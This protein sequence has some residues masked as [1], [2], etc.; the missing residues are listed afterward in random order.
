MKTSYSKFLIIFAV[1]AIGAE[2]IASSISGNISYTGTATGQITIVA[3]TD[4]ATRS[5]AAAVVTIASPG[6]YTLT[7]LSDT[8][9][10]IVA[11]MTSGSIDNVKLTDP[12]GYYGPQGMLAP[13]T[14]I[15]GGSISGINI[16]LE[17]GSKDNPNPFYRE[18]ISPTSITQLPDLTKPGT[19]PAIVY[20]GSWLYLY[21][22]DFQDAASGKV[23]KINPYSG[24]VNTTYIL[25]QESSPNRISWIN[26]LTF[27][28][29]EFWA[30]GGYGDPAG[31][32]YIN[33]VFKVDFA[34]SNSS[35]QLPANSGIDLTNEF[36]GLTND[37]V[38][39]Y[40]GANLKGVAP[41]PG[42]IKF[43]PSHATEIPA[44]PFFPL[45]YRPDYLCFGDGCLW[46]GVDSVRKIDSAN[47]N[48][49]G[50][51][52]LPSSSAELYFDNKFWRY[53]SDDNTLEAFSI[54]ALDVAKKS[55]AAAP[56]G[57]YLSQN[58]PNPFNPSTT[59][60]FGLPSRSF[61]SLKV[62]DLLG[63]EVATLVSDQLPAGNY[64]HQWNAAGMSSGMYFYR[65]QAGSYIKTQR[66][67]L[68][69]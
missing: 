63:K 13:L 41:D 57:F 42:I 49:L 32:G 17:D 45:G 68:L 29:G 2:A 44:A 3:I 18:T 7:G 1:M 15:S 51:Y 14:I 39:F 34:T 33:G 66:L 43:N 48:V 8:T 6:S 16:V 11:T 31:S 60:S 47:G 61:V 24:E 26:R 69:K 19:D 9:Y 10:Y 38:N 62:F 28:K 52:A 27:Y 30:V 4:T 21:K 25:A 58:F 65:L 53:N 50:A 35:N 64:T 40:V 22:H 56:L 5:N 23:Y 12:W 55:Y 36:G 54:T 67:L 20:D 59:I 46:A 37:G